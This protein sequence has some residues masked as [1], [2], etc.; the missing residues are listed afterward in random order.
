MEDQREVAASH[1]LGAGAGES[2][3]MATEAVSQKSAGSLDPDEHLEVPV[4][5]VAAVLALI[6]ALVEALDQI[7]QE[8]DG[9]PSDA[10]A[11][12]ELGPRLQSR[13]DEGSLPSWSELPEVGGTADGEGL[14]LFLHQLSRRLAAIYPVA[15]AAPPPPPITRP[16]NAEFPIKIASRS[17]ALVDDELSFEEALEAAPGERVMQAY[18]AANPILL[19][20][21][22]GGGHGRWVIPQKRLG[23]E[24]VTDFVIGDKDSDGRHWQFVELQDPNARLFVAPAV[25]SPSNLM[26]VSARFW[27]GGVGSTTTETMRAVPGPQMDS[28]SSTCQ[29]E[30]PGYSFS[31]VTAT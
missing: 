27:S 20:Q 7:D 11:L 29:G 15:A 17:S 12:K 3:E 14:R 9:D 6:D 28:V 18:L 21:H 4:R 24:Y 1:T 8:A 22:L 19:V 16:T 23:S 5:E 26:R 31:A 30:I 13:W 25:A 2:S 10:V